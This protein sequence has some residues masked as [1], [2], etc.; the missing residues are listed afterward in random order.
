MIQIKCK[1][2]NVVDE[3]LFSK[4]L[5]YEWNLSGDDKLNHETMAKYFAENKCKCASIIITIQH[6][7]NS[8]Y[9]DPNHMH[10]TNHLMCSIV[11]EEARERSLNRYYNGEE[12]QKIIE[13]YELPKW[14]VNFG[15]NQE[16][17]NKKFRVELEDAIFEAQKNQ[18]YCEII[19][20]YMEMCRYDY[21]EETEEDTKRTDDQFQKA[22]TQEKEKIFMPRYRTR[23]DRVY[24]MPDPFC[25]WDY[26]N[27]FQQYY[28]I[29]LDNVIYWTKGGTG[30]SGQREHHGRYAHTF[31]MLEHNYKYTIPTYCFLYDE[32]NIFRHVKDYK[33]FKAI[34]FDLYGNYGVDWSETK[35]LFE[36]R[37]LKLDVKTASLIEP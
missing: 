37:L 9:D 24:H 32:M 8:L 18:H 16:E 29:E 22:W 7:N 5:D 20:E 34:V 4:P 13:K 11:E 2:Q 10:K 1:N 12:L 33:T 27:P 15:D 14:A 17:E 3:V 6:L 31:A 35:Y 26:R 28:F 25:H 19:N 30:S 36:E 23:Y 21:N